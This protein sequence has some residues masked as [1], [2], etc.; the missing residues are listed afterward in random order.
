MARA[1]ALTAARSP[2]IELVGE[3]DGYNLLRANDKAYGLAQALGPVALLG[4]R[5]G[6]REMPP[7]LVIGD[8]VEEVA[9]RIR[10]I[11]DADA[12]ARTAAAR[13][14]Q[15][16]E[17]SRCLSAASSRHEAAL[18]DTEGRL[19]QVRIESESALRVS[20]ERTAQLQRRVED[21]TGELGVAQKRLTAV[22]AD[23]ERASIERRRLLDEL[24]RLRIEHQRI[25]DDNTR[26]DQECSQ[27]T[28]TLASKEDELNEVQRFI[29]DLMTELVELKATWWYRWMVRRTTT[30]ET[31]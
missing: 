1:E 6:E 9:A 11:S 14:T 8:S 2:H 30:A 5:L 16:E 26:L 19:E 22:A 13:I 28:G 31:S 12:D 24:D 21:I 7:G 10:A 18:R 25:K 20:H 23:L 15:L 29:D 27:L 4:E 3:V 17:E